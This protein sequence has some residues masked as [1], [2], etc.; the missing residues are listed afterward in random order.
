MSETRNFWDREIPMFLILPGAVLMIGFIA[1]LYDRQPRAVATVSAEQ[2]EAIRTGISPQ[3]RA[4]QAKAAAAR[5][6]RDAAIAA[7]DTANPGE[8]IAQ[9][10]ERAAR[11]HY[12]NTRDAV[13]VDH[14]APPVLPGHIVID[15]LKSGSIK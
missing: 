14:T 1:F 4:D 8:T 11:D 15:N 5:A 3:A 10:K 13:E 6:A 12:V 7:Y 9:A 2:I